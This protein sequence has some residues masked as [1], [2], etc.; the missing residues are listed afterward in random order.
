MTRSNP[1]KV[2]GQVEVFAPTGTNPYYRLRWTE[3][4]GS[5]GD[6]SAWRDPAAALAK[7]AVVDRRLARAAGPAAMARLGQ[8]FREYRQ[9]RPP[10]PEPG[11]VHAHVGELL[12][13][14]N[15]AVGRSGVST[16]H[17]CWE[18]RSLSFA[19][20]REV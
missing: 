19:F 16:T 7:A 12:P 9:G 6:T 1:A 8:I 15:E 20:R 11:P 13:A 4:D 2:V 18:S 14:S 3:P 17:E 5:P 10:G